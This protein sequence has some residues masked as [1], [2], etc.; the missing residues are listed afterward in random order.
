MQAQLQKNNKHT[1]RNVMNSLLAQ[2]ELNFEKEECAVCIDNL[3]IFS[4][5]YFIYKSEYNM[6]RKIREFYLKN[7]QLSEQEIVNLSCQTV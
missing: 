3:L 7:V 5:E 2:V 1:V 4:E 6:D